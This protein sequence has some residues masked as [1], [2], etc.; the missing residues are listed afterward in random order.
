ME[1]TTL[2]YNELVVVVVVQHDMKC[3]SLSKGIKVVMFPSL[4]I[5]DAIKPT[6]QPSHTACCPGLQCWFYFLRV[7]KH[8]VKDL[9]ESESNCA[10]R[11]LSWRVMMVWSVMLTGGKVV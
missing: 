7:V 9:S 10:V 11:A 4:G 3:L 5:D 2:N 1:S 8:E 6:F